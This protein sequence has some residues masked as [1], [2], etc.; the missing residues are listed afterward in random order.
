MALTATVLQAVRHAK[1]G[2][3]RL[4]QWEHRRPQFGFLRTFQEDTKNLLNA[5]IIEAA[6]QAATHVQSAVVTT[7]GGVTINNVRSCTIADKEN[8]SALINF[9]WAT[10]SQ[11]FTMLPSQY[12]N[13]EIDYAVDFAQKLE[14]MDEGFALAFETASF[15]A[16]NAAKNVAAAYNAQ[17]PYPV[18]GDFMA[19]TQ[20]QKFDFYNQ[21]RLIFKLHNFRNLNINIVG[22]T[23]AEADVMRYG[24]NGSL[25]V[26]GKPQTA[27]AYVSDSFEAWQMNG[28]NWHFSEQIPAVASVES[29]I[30]ASA[31]GSYGI[32]NW[33]PKAFQIGA[34]TSD[35]TTFEESA[36]MPLSGMKFGHQYKSECLTG[37]QVKEF[38]QFSTDVCFVTAYNSTPATV[39]GP[40]FEARIATT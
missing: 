8:T 17:T 27:N 18:V 6:K 4:D 26:V 29:R 30:F 36:V 1:P 19:V 37:D 2:V 21:L 39:A 28:Y 23:L 33:N 13:N 10:Y 5:G 7:K 40:I 25:K 9:V 15:N 32:M 34:K 3:Q 11:D 35:G 16:A 31:P 38:H 22:S 12:F 20:A 24:V 14:E